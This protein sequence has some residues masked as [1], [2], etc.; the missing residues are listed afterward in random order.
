MKRAKKSKNNKLIIAC[1]AALIVIVIVVI[2]ILMVKKTP[3]GSNKYVDG[4]MTLVDTIGAGSDYEAK[5]YISKNQE[6]VLDVKNS[7]HLNLYLKTKDTAVYDTYVVDNYDNDS[8]VKYVSFYLNSTEIEYEEKPDIQ[9]PAE[10][11]LVFASDVVGVEY[12]IKIKLDADIEYISG[13]MT[14]SEINNSNVYGY[15][16]FTEKFGEPPLPDKSFI[17]YMAIGE[18]RFGDSTQMIEQG[19]CDYF[20]AGNQGQLIVMKAS[21]HDIIYGELE[22]ETLRKITVN[23][24]SVD[25]FTDIDRYIAVYTIG[26]NMYMNIG[27]SEADE[28]IK[29]DE[30]INILKPF[31]K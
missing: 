29:D 11:E 10:C 27:F 4:E 26:E 31:I 22:G 20:S 5:V 7:R 23:D 6:L 1:I 12:S 28:N 19:R 13:T 24:V 21:N 9:Y 3:S 14:E 25:I 18:D 8:K 17:T 16:E 15:K 2:V 30:L